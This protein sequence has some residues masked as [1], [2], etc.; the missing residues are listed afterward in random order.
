MHVNRVAFLSWDDDK[1]G[2]HFE[3]KTNW[4]QLS[5]LLLAWGQVLAVGQ[6]LKPEP[7]TNTDKMYPGRQLFPQ[8]ASCHREKGST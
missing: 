3:L 7:L 6:K 4:L 1:V 2:V 8:D 5:I